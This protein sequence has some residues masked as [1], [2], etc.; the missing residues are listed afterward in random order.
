LRT[1]SSLFFLLSPLLRR[2]TV[3]RFGADR[4]SG[5]KAS[6]RHPSG[7]G[8]WR[9]SRALPGT[10]THRAA[11]NLGLQACRLA[12]HPLAEKRAVCGS[13]TGT[14]PSATPRSVL[15]IHQIS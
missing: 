1:A 5:E 7:V 2:L 3:H 11:H 13:V 4:S 14:H 9:S 12:Q 15:S 8:R 6:Y 10:P